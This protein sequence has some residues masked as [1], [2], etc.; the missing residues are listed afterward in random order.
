MSWT[1]PLMS[2]GVIV[3]GSIPAIFLSYL[4]RREWD[5]HDRK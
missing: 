5:K 4:F 1:F 3:I 2:I